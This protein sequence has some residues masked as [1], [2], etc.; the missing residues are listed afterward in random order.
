V[1]A[2]RRAFDDAAPVEVPAEIVTD[3]TYDGFWEVAR[4]NRRSVVLARMDEDGPTC[5]VP[6]PP[7]VHELVKKGDLLGFELGPK[8]GDTRPIHLVAAYPKAY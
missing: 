2:L 3:A 4:R 6:L 5:R 8:T 1:V 7:E